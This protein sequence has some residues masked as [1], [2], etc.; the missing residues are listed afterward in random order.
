MAA[1]FR[2]SVA[3]QVADML[4]SNVSLARDTTGWHQKSKAY[5]MQCARLHHLDSARRD[6]FVRLGKVSSQLAASR[7]SAVATSP[8]AVV[9]AE[10]KPWAEAIAVLDAD[11]V[12][13]A[14][15]VLA[16][17]AATYSKDL[18]SFV[19]AKLSDLYA[20]IRRGRETE[21][22]VRRRIGKVV[23]AL[24]DPVTVGKEEL[25]HLS[26]LVRAAAERDVPG[27]IEDIALTVSLWEKIPPAER[28]AVKNPAKFGASLRQLSAGEH[29][30]CRLLALDLLCC[31]DQVG[32]YRDAVVQRLA[33]VCAAACRPAS[34]LTAQRAANEIEQYRGIATDLLS[35]VG[36][37][38]SVS[39][40]CTAVLTD[41][42]R[43]PPEVN[44]PQ[45]RQCV[46]AAL[47]ALLKADGNRVKCIGAFMA[48]AATVSDGSAWWDAL[49]ET[50]YG[51][52]PRDRTSDYL[53]N[54]AL[55]AVVTGESR[56]SGVS[57]G[58]A[59]PTALV[60]VAAQCR[61]FFRQESL[62]SLVQRLLREMDADG[63]MVAHYRRYLR[64]AS[65]LAEAC[66]DGD[67]RRELIRAMSA[68]TV[69]QPS[70]HFNALL[71][72]IC[73]DL[74]S[75]AV[76]GTLGQARR[77]SVAREI[78]RLNNEDSG[79]C[80]AGMGQLEGTIRKN[81]EIVRGVLAELE[82]LRT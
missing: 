45:E 72:R 80:P 21:K 31:F 38:E 35:A 64:Q 48:V 1:P 16:N 76:K 20:E 26:G 33:S 57:V 19:G 15:D 44:K 11:A 79:T 29:E 73:F 81:L 69:A 25:Q 52:S 54:T 58:A 51:E 46:A 65:L 3:A 63:N 34:K 53:F 30:L 13:V 49:L 8:A 78:Q 74:L 2:E 28:A 67:R 56:L 23:A 27:A 37:E 47:R 41:L 40:L 24:S 66:P 77:R 22:G 59:L 50:C 36:A 32:P 17:S 71:A 39:E 5:L 9:S 14:F 4:T 82:S 68:Y 60:T 55:N 61:E 62:E 42:G 12:R 7:Q 70:E 43:K 18:R 10:M 75:V 6:V